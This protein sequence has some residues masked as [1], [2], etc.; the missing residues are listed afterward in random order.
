MIKNEQELQGT[1]ER[2]AYFQR[3]LAQLR[4]NAAPDEFPIVASG[5][6]SEIERMQAEVLDYLTRPIAE[7]ARAGA[8]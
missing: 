5:Y 2:I 3:R 1:T 4:M 8:A 7:S 6:R